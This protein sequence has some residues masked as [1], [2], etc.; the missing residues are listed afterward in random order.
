MQPTDERA[1]FDASDPLNRTRNWRNLVQRAM[2]RAKHAAQVLIAEH[3]KVVDTLAADR[4][5]QPPGR[6]VLPR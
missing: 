5:N 6:T 2:C 3:H 4:A 1:R